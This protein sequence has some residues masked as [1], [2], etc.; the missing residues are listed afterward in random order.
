MRVLILTV[1][2][3]AGAGFIQIHRFHWSPKMLSLEA[4]AAQVLLEQWGQR[5]KNCGST[6]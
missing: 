2:S 6:G 4:Q 1:C 5:D 3:Y